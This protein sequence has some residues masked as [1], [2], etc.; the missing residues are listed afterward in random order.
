M[1]DLK[2]NHALLCGELAVLKQAEYS[3]N[4]PLWQALQDVSAR[5]SK[6]LLVHIQRE[7]QWFKQNRSL[8]AAARIV[9][10]QTSIDHYNDYRYLQVITRYITLEN[11]PF[12]INSRY[13]LL[14]DFIR[15]LRCHMDEQEAQLFPASELSLAYLTADTV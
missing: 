3:G 6:G 8:G 15:G 11:R 4:V 7:A 13:R 12:L 1:D 10:A 9:M 14:T 5:L 2:E